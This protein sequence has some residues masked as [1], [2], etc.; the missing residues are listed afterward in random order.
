MASR[1]A[2]A[3]CV[4]DGE[5]VLQRSIT[6]IL[7]SMTFREILMAFAGGRFA[8]C[9][10]DTQVKVGDATSKYANMH[11]E[12]D[13]ADMHMTFEATLAIVGEIKKIVYLL[14]V[15]PTPPVTAAPA[16]EA[17]PPPPPAIPYV[18]RV[19]SRKP[20]ES[21]QTSVAKQRILTEVAT[22]IYENLPADTKYVH[23][24]SKYT[25]PSEPPFPAHLHGVNLD[26]ALFREWYRKRRLEP[27]VVEILDALHFVWDL[28]Q[29]KW[30][31]HL[32]CLQTFRAL[33]GH[34][35]VP[36]RF[37]VPADDPE[38]P[39][40]LVGI[41]LGHVVHNIRGYGM[42]S[43]QARSKELEALGFI[44]DSHE[45][46]FQSHL[47]ALKR[48]KELHGHIKVPQFFVVPSDDET[49]PA[50]FWGL[51]LGRVV[52]N[53]R[54][55]LPL[56]PA[57]RKQAM[58]DLGMVWCASKKFSWENRLLG[59][60]TYHR[61]YNHLKVPKSFQVPENDPSWPKEVWN[62]QLGW[63][64]KDLRNKEHTMPLV[65]KRKLE[66]M[67]FVWTVHNPKATPPSTE[68][69][70]SLIQ[71]LP[72]GLL[73]DNMMLMMPTPTQPMMHH[74][75]PFDHAAAMHHHQQQHQ[76]QQQQHQQ[77]Q[78]QQQQQQLHHQFQK[79]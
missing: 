22:I 36:D 35:R 28:N 5:T 52:I 56:L 46:T 61:F 6:Q 17:L 57:S 27:D 2:L 68:T 25:V 64:V 41:H 53:L 55:R 11:T 7:P 78:Q 39:K 26:I 10:A 13:E 19:R 20:S 49:W 9:I 70:P 32:R 73:T 24:P 4:M 58:D 40:D 48:F 76:Q 15:A 14:G 29:F 12:M 77:Q 45:A 8:A 59:L 74:H 66:S 33:K 75:M 63:V 79:G 51:K 31:L 30:D 71:A 38:W 67:G 1:T 54:Q 16:N 50:E 69:P 44:W 60:E 72:T 62:M 37:V 65:R 34:L 43:K 42:E 47:V 18:Q 21:G 3:V 23:L